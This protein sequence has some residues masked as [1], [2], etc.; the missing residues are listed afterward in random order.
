MIEPKSLVGDLCGAGASVENTTGKSPMR[1]A[2]TARRIVAA[3]GQAKVRDIL[4]ILI[5]VGSVLRAAPIDDINGI[6]FCWH[7]R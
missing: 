3:R 6:L 2:R 5:F 1:S 7:Q 4:S